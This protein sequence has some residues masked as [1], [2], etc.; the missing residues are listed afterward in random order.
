MQILHEEPS[1]NCISNF[2]FLSNM[3]K[4][5]NQC[6]LAT[7]AK[8]KKELYIKYHNCHTSTQTYYLMSDFSF[9][10]NYVEYNIEQ[11]LKLQKQ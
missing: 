1:N 2:A 8:K 5:F 9:N 11:G 6:F 7:A 3:T 4:D 10:V